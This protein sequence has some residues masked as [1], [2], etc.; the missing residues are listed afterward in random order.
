MA[1]LTEKEQAEALRYLGY[2]NWDSVASSFQLGFPSTSQPE[3]LVRDA[4]N[5]ITEQGL[6][7]LRRDLQELRCIENQISDARGR[8]KAKK[9]GDLTMNEDEIVMLRK[10][11][12]YWAGR[13]SDDLGGYFNPF[14][15][16]VAAG[17]RNARVVNS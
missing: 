15:H 5:R 13:L 1:A 8:F 6:E 10:E 9:V 7:L 11:M 2:T 12:T 14:G 4:F 17:G 3:F 16:D